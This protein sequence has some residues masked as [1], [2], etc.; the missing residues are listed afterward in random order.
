MKCEICGEEIGGNAGS[1][2]IHYAFKHNGV[3]REKTIKIE[4]VQK[5]IINDYTKGIKGSIICKKYGI[6]RGA[7]YKY[8]KIWGVPLHGNIVKR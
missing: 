7:L 3:K 4:E 6:S 2:S 5:E 1:L 8:L